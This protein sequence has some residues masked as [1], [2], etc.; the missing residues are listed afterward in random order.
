MKSSAWLAI[1]AFCAI[2]LGGCTT[3]SKVM[4]NSQNHEMQTMIENAQSRLD[5]PEVSQYLQEIGTMVLESARRLD[6]V[7]DPSHQPDKYLD[8]YQNFKV[9]AVNDVLPNAFVT[10]NDYA[11]VNTALLSM[12]E[13]P[14][15][16]VMILGH[17]FGHLRRGH[18]VQH[19]TNVQYAVVAGAIA[20]EVAKAQGK[21]KSQEERNLAGERAAATMAAVFLPQTPEK[22]S[23]S[24]ATAVE[25]M[26]ELGLD[27]QHADD[28]FV[29]MLKLYGDAE[30]SH[31]KP[32][33][34][35]ARV[36]A[37]IAQLESAGYK[38]TRTLDR[39]RFLA[40]RERIRQIVSDGVERKTIVYFADEMA[41]ESRGA[42][43]VKPLG[44][45]PLYGDAAN[46]TAVFYKAIGVSG[47]R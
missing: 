2:V 22:E 45:G 1:L 10:G 13:S 4:V 36:N 20:R 8:I 37:Q 29:R 19:M 23:E 33:V 32:S 6:K 42:A 15:E 3:L 7:N 9:L 25:I 11:A 40:V 43:I 16:L 46:A 14:E 31:P 5:D 30:G 26:A 44:C 18:Q 47:K 21:G 28:F 35:I 27:L 34:R 12:A 41:Q 39:G 38:P 17:E 24:D